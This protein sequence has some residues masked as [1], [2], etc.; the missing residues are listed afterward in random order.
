MSVRATT[1]V[2]ILHWN[3]PEECLRTVHALRA[4]TPRLSIRV[5]DNASD[6]D[7]LRSLAERLPEDVKLIRLAE[8]RGWGGAF[9]V[10]LQNWL[11][12]EEGE[13]CFIGAHD[14][15]PAEASLSMLIDSM[16]KDP[17]LGVVCP[18]YGA[19]EVPRFSR[20]RYVR[21]TPVE[22]RPSGTVEPVDLPNGTLMLFRRQCLQ[23][24]GLFD[25]RYFA[26][27]DEHE[28]GLR[29]RR[30]HWKVAIVWG[31]VVLNPGT[32]TSNW[33]RSYLFTRNS[34]LLVRT[35]AGKWAATVRLLSMIPNTLRM[36]MVHP[37]EGYAFSAH[38]RFAGMR[39]FVMGRYGSPPAHHR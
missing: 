22:P 28:I 8:N 16:Q 1:P 19:P 34:L 18:E 10:V 35:Y 26:Y 23:D 32:W 15:L 24:I 31:S 29:A 3:R 14:A 13:F 33:T 9:N 2:F 11:Q 21:I 27:G 36:W 20:L 6:P 37:A 30:Q 38:A 5:I 39:D 17:K 7:L 25:E 4:Q 12:T